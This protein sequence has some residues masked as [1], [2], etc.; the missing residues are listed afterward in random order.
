[1]LHHH[2]P[3]EAVQQSGLPREYGVADSV[4]GIKSLSSPEGHD[5]RPRRLSH[6]YDDFEQPTAVN[7]MFVRRYMCLY[8]NRFTFHLGAILHLLSYQFCVK[9]FCMSNTECLFA[10]MVQF[11][12]VWLNN[13]RIYNLFQLKITEQRTNFNFFSKLS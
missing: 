4:H 12:E 10:F 2:R 9:T 11:R 5:K 1:M 3:G 7:T 13:Q 6:K 8:S